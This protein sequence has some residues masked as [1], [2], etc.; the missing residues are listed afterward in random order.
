[1]LPPTGK[2]H[3]KCYPLPRKPNSNSPPVPRD[4]N[5]HTIRAN[6]TR[7]VGEQKCLE[8]FVR[9]PDLDHAAEKFHIVSMDGSCQMLG[10]P[11]GDLLCDP[12]GN[13]AV[14]L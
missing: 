10:H 2:A 1:M 3:S 11:V 12:L 7:S 8:R 14:Q 6:T 5:T 13:T 4:R 9:P